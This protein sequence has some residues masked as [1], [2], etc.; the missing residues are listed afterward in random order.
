MSPVSQPRLPENT[1]PCHVPCQAGG[2]LR[3]QPADDSCHTVPSAERRSQ[4]SSRTSA[5]GG[6]ASQDEDTPPSD[7]AM[8][9]QLSASL[10]PG[11]PQDSTAR[12]LPSPEAHT[13]AYSEDFESSPSPSVSEPA[14]PSLECPDRAVEAWSESSSSLGPPTCTA[15]RGKGS[16]AV[17]RGL[18][19]E[20][21]V[22]TLDCALT[23]PWTAGACGYPREQGWGPPARAAA[24][25]PGSGHGESEAAL[26]VPAGPCE[27]QI[28]SEPQPHLAPGSAAQLRGLPCHCG[29]LPRGVHAVTALAAL[30]GWGT[31]GCQPFPARPRVAPGGQGKPCLPS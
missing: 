13:L 22:Q 2:A 27:L 8:S 6:A 31:Q 29:L 26:C 3:P 18:V 5:C 7:G 1:D 9:E 16:R 15:P 20:T 11:T 14:T 25:R 24:R 19:K 12:T 17:H 30:P 4:S 10:A 23:Y 28:T 21:A